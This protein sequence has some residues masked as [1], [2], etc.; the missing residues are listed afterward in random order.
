VSVKKLF[1][2]LLAVLAVVSG[3][4][5]WNY[6]GVYGP[7]AK[8]LAQDERNLKVT[9]WAYRQYGVSPSTV[10]FDLRGVNQDAAA[11]DVTRALF[12][13]AESLKE[14]RFELVILAHLG[15][16]KL[17]LQGDYF[18]DLGQRFKTE[19]P[20]FLLRTLPENVHKLDGSKAYG[21]WTGGL[22]GVVGKQM[23]DLGSM[24]KDWFLADMAALK[25]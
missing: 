16:A 2:G 22:L 4:G 6:F 3:L 10:V 5:A 18:Q 21:T 15:E 13:G 23:E 12:Q 8:R 19:N 1:F 14:T 24:A 20:V 11:L 25:P 17:Y 9:V 7:V